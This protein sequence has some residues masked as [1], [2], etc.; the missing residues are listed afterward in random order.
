[1]RSAAVARGYKNHM[2]TKNVDL[3]SVIYTVSQ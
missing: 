1:M 2:V 3:A